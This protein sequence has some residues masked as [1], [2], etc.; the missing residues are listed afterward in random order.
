MKRDLIKCNSINYRKGYIEVLGGIHDEC[1]NLEVWNIHPDVDI[2]SVDLGDES[3]PEN[4]VASN[5]EI[6]L[7]LEK[8]ELLI[9]QLTLAVNKIRE[10][11]S[12]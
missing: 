5:T 9:E 8:A 2:T 12:P 6:E 10:Y 3:F 11:N 4:A 7:S 1:I